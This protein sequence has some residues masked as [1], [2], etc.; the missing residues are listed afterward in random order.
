MRKYSVHTIA[1]A[2]HRARNHTSNTLHD[3]NTTHLSSTMS[4][5]TPILEVQLETRFDE[6]QATIALLTDKPKRP[7]RGRSKTETRQNTHGRSENSSSLS[8][9][10]QISR[11]ILPA[12]HA[13]IRKR[14]SITWNPQLMKRRIACTQ[15]TRPKLE[16][17]PDDPDRLFP[18][19][20][21]SIATVTTADVAS[22]HDQYTVNTAV[23]TM[24]T[25]TVV[26][27]VDAGGRSDII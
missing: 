6:V 16:L 15:Y 2:H 9:A 23:A 12:Q 10:E 27:T 17:T 7:K 24:S 14:T 1:A 5:P 8:G 21:G 20:F 25:D 18:Y 13:R 11:K 4:A 26:V 22:R 19:R 3:V